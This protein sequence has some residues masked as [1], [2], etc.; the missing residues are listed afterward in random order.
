MPLKLVVANKAYSSWSLRPWILLAHFKIPFEEVVIPMAEPGTRAEM[1]KYAPTGKCPSLHDGRIAVW[2]SLAIVEYVAELH[3]EKPIWPKGK[4]ARAHARSLASEMHAG[5]GALRSEAPCNFRRSPKAVALSD[6]ARGDV[7][8][9][10][11]AWAEAR[12]T[13]GKAGP[14]LYGRFSAAD[15]MFA[16]VVNRLHAYAVPVE[17]ATRDYME[18]IMALPAWKAWIADAEAEPWRIEKYEAY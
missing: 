11:A 12:E 14:F 4:A 18:A 15:A 13:F 6:A 9:I 8:R 7:A 5:F 17:P 16:P 2:E 1:L 10:E 3:P